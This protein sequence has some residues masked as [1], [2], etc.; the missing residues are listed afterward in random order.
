MNIRACNSNDMDQLVD[1]WLEGSKRAHD[2]ID[3]EYW[4]ANKNE[5]KINYI[6]NSE[7]YL[8]E[9][10]QQITGFV[11]MVDDYLA[12]LFVD[13]GQQSKGYGKALLDYIKQKRDNIQLKVYEQNAQAVRFYLKNDFK[14]VEEALDEQ[15]QAKEYVMAWT[16]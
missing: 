7:T 11:S 2:F 1:I 3:S 5:M 13:P 15:T 10:N 12:A 8:S 16:K 4:E 14:I 9:A 6:P